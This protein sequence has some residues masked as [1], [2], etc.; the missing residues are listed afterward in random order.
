MVS[1]PEPAP[2][3]RAISSGLAPIRVAKVWR[4]LAATE[5]N[6]RLSTICGR[7][8]A[9]TEA[10]TAL[11]AT[12]GIAACAAKF[13]YVTSSNGYHSFIQSIGCFRVM[14]NSVDLWFPVIGVWLLI[15]QNSVG[16]S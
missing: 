16:Y 12:R 2:F 7:I 3:V 11:R 10:C 8:F 6:A 1:A 14:L 9:A 5:K 13:R 4:R 15:P